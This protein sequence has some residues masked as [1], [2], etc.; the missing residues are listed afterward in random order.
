M[1][2]TVVEL[3]RTAIADQPADGAAHA[4][5][6]RALLA[7][8]RREEALAA[9]AAALEQAP[10]QADPWVARGQALLAANHPVQAAQAWEHALAIEPGRAALCANLGV[11]Y[12]NLERDADAEGWLTR[13]LA[14]DPTLRS[15][16]A[17]LGSLR[18]RTDRNAAE[19]HWQAAFQGRAVEIVP[20]QAPD[21]RRVLVPLMAGSANVPIQYLLPRGRDTVIRWMIEF[22]A[23]GDEGRLPGYDLV[24]NGIGDPD[25][26]A[27][28][29]AALDRFLAGCAR[30]VL[31]RPARVAATRR[32]R[33]PL[34][35]GDLPGVIVPRVL[36]IGT[37]EPAATAAARAGL[38]LPLLVRPAGAHGGE[39][40]SRLATE[41]ELQALAPGAAYY[42][43]EFHPYQSPDGLWR[44]LRVVFVDGEP[45][46]YHLAAGES[47]L[48]HYWTAG[49]ETHPSRQAEERRFLDDPA[50]TLGAAAW[51]AI[52]AIG[53]RLGLDWCGLDFACLED[54]QILVFEANATMSVHP[55]A[56][57]GV[58]AYK[59]PAVATIL[60]A[61]DAMLARR[62]DV[63]A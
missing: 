58:L 59:N 60:G 4:G 36:R 17:T 35:L 20:S 28:A 1:R 50:A 25:E 56:A 61:F 23:P 40:V 37:D 48:C 39:G 15:A 19:Q 53:R 3:Y 62:T 42:L 5:L 26:G 27:A 22:A 21:A 44:K 38:S 10:G 32:D 54:G 6:A 31:N 41:A 9:S 33:L 57:D 18:A 14:L 29:A 13:A 51:D 63:P 2:D 52:C 12:A 46:P 11:L 49:M 24:F 43:T 47:W 55:E 16:H 34:L 8:G 45:F 7:A 30:P